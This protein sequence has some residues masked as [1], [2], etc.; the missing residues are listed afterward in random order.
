MS[1]AVAGRDGA[2]EHHV[3]IGGGLAAARAA[4]GMRAAGFTGQLSIV[5]GEDEYPYIRPPLSKEYLSGSAER[6]SIFVHDAAWY[7][8]HDVRVLRGR[9]AVAVTLADQVVSLD[10]GDVLHYDRLLIASGARSRRYPGPGAELDGVHHLRTV[11]ESEAL[12]AAL[13]PGGKRVVIIGS[14]WIGLE[15]AAAARGYGNTVTVLGRESVP[16]ENVVGPEIGAVFDALHRANGVGLRNAAGVSGIE[17]GV[18]ERAGVVSGVRLSDGE[19]L[20]ADLVVVGIGALPNVELAEAAGLAL[21][22]GI[23]VDE[24]FRS[25]H[26]GVFAVGDV[27]NVFHPVL[28]SHLRV[29]HWATAKDAGFAAGESMA[30]RATSYEQIPYFYTDQF[31]LG[32]EYSGYGIWAADAE[33]VVRGNLAEREFIAFWLRAD[34]VVAGMNV[35]VWD[36]N[37]TVQALIRSAE[38]VDAARLADPAVPLAAL[39]G[40]RP[41]GAVR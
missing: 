7:A 2:A 30:G 19:L 31:D 37:E 32:M 41:S 3:I 34:R 35:N 21:D 5:A 24:G 40:A 13:A 28:G 9:T 39:L 20:Q 18:G 8:E 26:P 36:V 16:L 1:V 38:P 17:G 22:N 23:L 29:E 25:S 10:G 27:A 4:E 15:V 33:L 11:G 12:A 6:A 14:G